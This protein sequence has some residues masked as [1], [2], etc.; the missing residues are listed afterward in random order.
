MNSG[1]LSIL[2]NNTEGQGSEI[3]RGE[4]VGNPAKAG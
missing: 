3:T 4:G 1:T 2:L